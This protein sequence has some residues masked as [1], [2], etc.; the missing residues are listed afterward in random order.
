MGLF[1][2]YNTEGFRL[3]NKFGQFR[4]LFKTK[5]LSE[6]IEVY[7]CIGQC[8]LVHVLDGPVKEILDFSYLVP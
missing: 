1:V 3:L 8:H 6:L 5:Y 2:A 4:V 7:T